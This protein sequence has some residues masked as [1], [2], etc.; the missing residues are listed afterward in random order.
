M[1]ISAILVIVSTGLLLWWFR[2][3]CRLILSA[4]SARDYTK[5]VAQANELQ[6]LEVQQDLVK[7]SEPRQLHSLEEKLARDYTLLNYLLCHG[8]AFL[9]R[10]DRLEHRLL[11]LHYNLMRAWYALTCKLSVS[12]SQRALQEMTQVI[13]YFANKMGE[14]ADY[15]L[16]AK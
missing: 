13:G 1:I 9:A 8:P 5:A 6:F 12:K 11:M 7:V 16:P 10:T 14:R 4:P 2:Y 15:A 3:S